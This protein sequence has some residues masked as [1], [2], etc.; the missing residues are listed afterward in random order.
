MKWV[1]AKIWKKQLAGMKVVKVAGWRSAVVDIAGQGR[2][3]IWF[4]F[5]WFK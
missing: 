1:F 3:R 5:W 4:C 2:Q